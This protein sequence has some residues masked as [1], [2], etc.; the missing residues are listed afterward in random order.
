MMRKEGK[1][2][3]IAVIGGASAGTKAVKGGAACGGIPVWADAKDPGSVGSRDMR[4]QK[5]EDQ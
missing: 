2:T 1:R 5:T 4:I 3:S